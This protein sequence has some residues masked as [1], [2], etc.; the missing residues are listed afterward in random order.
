[1]E[2]ATTRHQHVAPAGVTVRSM[3]RVRRLSRTRTDKSTCEKTGNRRTHPMDSCYLHTAIAQQVAYQRD[4]SRTLWRVAPSHLTLTD[5]TIN[6]VQ[7]VFARSMC[8]TGQ[9]CAWTSN[10][11]N[12]DLTKNLCEMFNFWLK[13]FVLSTRHM[14]PALLQTHI[15]LLTF[16]W[17]QEVASSCS[18]SPAAPLAAA[19]LLL[20]R[21]R[22]RAWM[23]TA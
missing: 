15:V 12:S 2:E 11:L 20:K 5:G 18:S 19:M 17:D 6:T 10:D 1:M 7:P 3:H 23:G 16:L 4:T 22:W 13:V 8:S 9:K 14:L 21:A